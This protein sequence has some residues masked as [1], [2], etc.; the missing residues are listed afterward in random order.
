MRRYV[1]LVNQRQLIAAARGLT[2][3]YAAN[4]SELL[5][6]VSAF[7][8]AYGAYAEFQERLERYWC[9]RWL[10]QERVTHIG[11]TVLREEVVRLDHLPLV[12]RLAGAPA[13]VRG[14]RIE[15]DVLA[16][17]LVALNVQLRLRDVLSSR[18]DESEL[19]EDEDATPVDVTPNA[20]AIATA[21]VTAEMTAGA[22]ADAAADTTGLAVDAPVDNGAAAR[23]PTA[24]PAASG[25][26]PPPNR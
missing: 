26:A 1:D 11:A 20:A 2:A 6:I 25:D 21:A 7:E 3:S 23:P 4:D 19:D 12:Q 14:Q 22:A 5:A 9:L 16:I 15:L 10:Q 8:T 24:A 17:D 18:A 13:L